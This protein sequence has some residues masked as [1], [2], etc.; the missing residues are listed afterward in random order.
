[1]ASAVFDGERRRARLAHELHETGD[2]GARGLPAAGRD[3]VVAPPRIVATGALPLVELLDQPVV[4]HALEGAVERAGAEAQRAVGARG[5]LL[6]DRVAV[7]VAVGE[8][9]EDVENGGGQ[10]HPR[11]TISRSD[12]STTVTVGRPLNGVR[13]VPGT[14]TRR[15]ARLRTVSDRARRGWWPGGRGS[16]SSRA[17]GGGNSSPSLS[18]RSCS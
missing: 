4:E 16:L 13:H 18:R 11:A 6:H 3:P 15:G 8:R 5:D 2:L 7:A 1:M 17:S 12:I 9:D 14:G 10:R